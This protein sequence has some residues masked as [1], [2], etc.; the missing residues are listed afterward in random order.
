[1]TNETDSFVQE[2]DESLAQDRLLKAARRFGPYL[3]GAFAAF[4]LALIGW[5]IWTAQRT[6]ASYA[7]SERFAAALE[8]A[9]AGDGAGAKEEFARLGE[10][11]PRS[12]RV[13]AL[14][15]SAALL[16]QDGDLQGALDGFDAAAEAA[17]D[18]LMRDTA[19]LRAAYIVAETQDFE[20][21]RARLQPLIDSDTRLSYMAK[22]L[23][24]IEAWEAGDTTLAR[25]TLQNLS[26]AFDAPQSVQQRA[27]A[28]LQVLGPAPAAPAAAPAPSEGETK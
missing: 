5:Q 4:L 12:Y 14:M 8:L 6:G 17:S 22:E 7:R 18:P 9:R 10:G 16:E 13:M 11:G 26:L 23:L 28:A 20:A 21:L 25:D 19:R 1:M 15:A 3:V 24:A 2:V 27:E